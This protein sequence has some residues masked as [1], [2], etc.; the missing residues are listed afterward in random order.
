[1][2]YSEKMKQT[3]LRNSKELSRDIHLACSEF[4]SLNRTF[5]DR[6]FAFSEW[7]RNR[8]KSG[9]K[10]KSLTKANRERLRASQDKAVLEVSN[11][12]NIKQSTIR[13]ITEL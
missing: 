6:Y 9:D 5:L 10:L 11:K 12:Y 13:K 8:Y 1:M 3:T 4:L 2:E 7:F